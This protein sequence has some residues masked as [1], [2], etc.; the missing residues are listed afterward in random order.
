M[1]KKMQRQ[2]YRN[3]REVVLFS[4]LGNHTLNFVCFIVF[5]EK[6]IAE[7]KKNSN[8]GIG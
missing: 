4:A 7:M 1:F 2:R 6:T 8:F 3:N 5:F